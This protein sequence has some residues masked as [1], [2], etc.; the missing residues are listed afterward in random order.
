MS[1]IPKTYSLSFKHK[2]RHVLLQKNF[3]QLGLVLSVVGALFSIS[4]FIKTSNSSDREL[5]WIIRI[6]S[7]GLFL[8]PIGLWIWLSRITDPVPD[9]LSSMS[10][11]FFEQNG[12]CFLFTADAKDSHARMNLFYQNRY[13]RLCLAK[14]AIGPTQ[15]A[16]ADLHGLPNF[17]FKVCCQ[18]GEYGRQS[19]A[20]SIPLRFQGKAVL[21]D[22]AAEVDYPSGQQ[23]ML[24]RGRTGVQVGDHLQTTGE[25]AV[26]AVTGL[27]GSMFHIHSHQAGP[28]RTELLLPT[29]I[30]PDGTLPTDLKSETIWTLGDPVQG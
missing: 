2:V 14:V 21:W 10:A 1:E 15:K 26:K 9:F 25:E 16:F 28:G 7:A 29:E 11:K 24:L 12:F 5:T 30:V 20:W 23:G 8:T 6:A 22:V 17:E 4:W 18:G 13:D 3:R 19:L 27:I